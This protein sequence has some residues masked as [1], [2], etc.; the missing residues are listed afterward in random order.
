MI[1][2]V[3]NGDP[4]TEEML[5]ERICLSE[6]FGLYGCRL[7]FPARGFNKFW[8][9]GEQPGLQVLLG[10]RMFHVP[11][12]LVRTRLETLAG[13]YGAGLNERL[14]ALK[15]GVP[16]RE[17]DTW[18]ELLRIALEDHLMVAV[19]PTSARLH[20]R[21]ELPLPQAFVQEVEPMHTA[22]LALERLWDAN[23]DLVPHLPAD[24]DWRA[25]TSPD[26]LPWASRINPDLLDT[27]LSMISEEFA[28]Q[29]NLECGRKAGID[30]V[31][32]E[33]GETEE[34]ER[35]EGSE[36]NGGDFPGIA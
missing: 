22:L 14:V 33:A 2:A 20:P 7:F 13:M 12:G 27:A 26:Q 17:Y 18:P 35:D 30:E 19:M 25:A 1:G 23:A 32:E 3:L 6:M 21:V 10:P 11:S 31:P 16:R 34:E 28:D 15:H 9:Y 8:D 24:G 29:L 4:A 36:S 5:Y